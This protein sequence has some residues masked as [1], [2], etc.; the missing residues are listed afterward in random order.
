MKNKHIVITVL[1]MTLLTVG[2]ASCLPPPENG[3]DTGPD[4]LIKPT[5]Y[6][7]PIVSVSA[8]GHD[9]NVPENVLD[10]D[11]DTRWSSYGVGEWISF[12]L[13]DTYE[14]HAIN[15]SWYYGDTRNAFFSVEYSEDNTRWVEVY[16]DKSSGETLD[17]E[18]YGLIDAAARYVRILG[19]GNSDS[20]WN[21]ITTVTIVGKKVDDNTLYLDYPEDKP[22]DPDD[23]E[24][25]LLEKGT[26]SV[27]L[28]KCTGHTAGVLG[29]VTAMGSN[30]VVPLGNSPDARYNY[31]GWLDGNEDA[32]IT[33]Y[34]R[35]TGECSDITVLNDVPRNSASGS[36]DAV[37]I[38][39]DGEG[40]IYASYYGATQY[41]LDG[42]STVHSGTPI[43]RSIQPLD[44]SS[45]GEMWKLRD[46]TVN[47][48]QMFRMRDGALLIAGS[49]LAGRIDIIEPGGEYRWTAPR[50]VIHQDT[51][52][53][54]EHVCQGNRFTKAHFHEGPD[55]TLYVVWG[56]GQGGRDECPDIQMYG[57]DSHEVFF[58]YS[59]DGGITWHNREG[60][61]AVESKL[62]YAYEDCSQW[63][64]LIPDGGIVH[65]DPDFML[66][67][68][69][70]RE[71][72]VTWAE[73]DGDIYVAFSKSMYCDSG[74][75]LTKNVTNPGALMLVKF[76]INEPDEDIEEIMVNADSE[77]FRVAGVRK[78][79]DVLY[80]WV[81]TWNPT[82]AFYEYISYD[83]GITWERNRPAIGSGCGNRVAGNYFI[84]H[85]NVASFL[86][87][88]GGTGERGLWLYER[89]V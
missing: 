19:R 2:I 86:I 24:E 31:I 45:F 36:H 54:R 30:T 75:C 74:V 5:I 76:N 10:G 14:V 46:Y 59:I 20:G 4:P 60:T 82:M 28:V 16:S 15:I 62:C 77:H 39:V 58:A 64:R 43:K 9:G 47:E 51:R 32:V 34:D 6:E 52:A 68:T 69:R 57:T 33:A 81:N 11:L 65:D 18:R 8:S 88:C 83:D 23:A 67:P 35:K 70:Q 26:L 53:M 49:D 29:K 61:R 73:P 89:I 27:D 48:R 84:P 56:W 37:G 55:G 63:N 22:S 78:A 38:G 17:A 80:I 42:H 40:H 7:L 13:D 66:T 79:G 72:R 71:H 25:Y 41:R 85:Q 3:F 1:L 44:S 21:S 87:Q 12:E 50:Q